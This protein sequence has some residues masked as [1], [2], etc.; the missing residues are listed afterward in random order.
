MTDEALIKQLAAR[1][2]D[3]IH[4]LAIWYLR[5]CDVCRN[6]SLPFP[7]S[8]EEETGRERASCKQ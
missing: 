8:R 4:T 3:G 1:L 6:H 5:D 7:A 2:H